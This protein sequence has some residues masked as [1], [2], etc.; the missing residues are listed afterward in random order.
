MFYDFL[1]LSFYYK[2]FYDKFIDNLFRPL[3]RVNKMQ[4]WF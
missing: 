2:F 1:H 4:T 3:Q